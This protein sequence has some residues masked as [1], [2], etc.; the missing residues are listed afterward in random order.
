MSDGMPDLTRLANAACAVQNIKTN[1]IQHKAHL[2]WEQ[3][4]AIVRYAHAHRDEVTIMY[5]EEY[6]RDKAPEVP[7]P[8][9]AAETKLD[10]D[11]YTEDGA[12]KFDDTML[13]QKNFRSLQKIAKDRSVPGYDQLMSKEELIDAI[14]KHQ[15]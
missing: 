5:P 6:L 8:V 13:R 14:L 12:Q 11:A 9:V 1:F 10:V 4:E 15:S 3:W 7:A 2:E